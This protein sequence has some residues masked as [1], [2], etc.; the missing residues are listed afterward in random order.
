MSDLT[1]TVQETKNGFHV[2]GY[3]KISYDFTFLDGVFNPENVLSLAW[4][5]L[6]AP[7]G[8]R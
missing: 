2:D 5:S 8:G 7:K 1:A 3:E 4:T 6:S